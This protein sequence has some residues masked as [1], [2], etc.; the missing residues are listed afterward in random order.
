M[1]FSS[2]KQESIKQCVEP[3]S[4]KALKIMVFGKSEVATDKNRALGS[5]G[6]E[7]LRRTSSIARSRSSQPEVRRGPKGCCLF[8]RVLSKFAVRLCNLCGSGSSFNFRGFRT[9]L[10]C[11]SYSTAEETQIIGESTRSLGW[12][13]FSILTK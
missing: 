9:I 2:T 11:M 8:F 10:C 6:A 13:K 7:A 4:T 1:F 5:K 12:G 3:E